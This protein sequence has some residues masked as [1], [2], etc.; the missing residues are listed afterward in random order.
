[1]LGALHATHPG[2]LATGLG[3]FAASGRTVRLDYLQALIGLGVDGIV[4]NSPCGTDADSLAVTAGA[5]GPI[6]KAAQ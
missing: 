2:S 6:V 5:I 4:V 3:T 1:M